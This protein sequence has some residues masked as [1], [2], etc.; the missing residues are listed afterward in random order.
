[1]KLSDIL[2]SFHQ[3]WETCQPLTGSSKQIT[4]RFNTGDVTS[5]LASSLAPAVCASQHNPSSSAQLCLGLFWSLH[6]LHAQPQVDKAFAAQ[7]AFA[8]RGKAPPAPPKA[9]LPLPGEIRPCCPS[10]GASG[11]GLETGYPAI[12]AWSCQSPWSLPRHRAAL[13]SCASQGFRGVPPSWFGHWGLLGTHST[14]AGSP[15]WS[16]E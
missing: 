1:M 12:P 7:A 3:W 16:P 4:V 5:D 13:Q 11:D 2:S 9:C 10:C 15:E 6:R 8:A 14:R